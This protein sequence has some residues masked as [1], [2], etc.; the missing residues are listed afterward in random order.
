MINERIRQLRLARKLSQI[1]L[2]NAINV[3]KQCISNW[4]NAYIQPPVDMVMRL[5]R[6]FDV[7]TDYLLGITNEDAI[8]V[9]GLSEQEITHIKL[10]IAD[11][12]ESKKINPSQ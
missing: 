8:S 3:T 6:Y 2:A 5:A 4:E 7:T 10:L 1:E 11:L 9:S 12:R